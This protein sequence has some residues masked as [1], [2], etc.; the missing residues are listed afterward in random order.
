MANLAYLASP[1]S[2]PSAEVR[3]WRF[4]AACLAV[5]DFMRRG[6]AVFSPVVYSH[7]TAE[8]ASLPLDWESWKDFDTR[9]LALCD[10]LLV[11]T[12]PGW[13]DSRG[14]SEEIRLARESGKP[15]QFVEP[16]VVPGWQPPGIE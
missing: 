10:S 14:V 12:L 4:E 13:R 8:I 15:V 7:S 3:R 2:H 5:A 6:V 9:F 11:L 16:V 1:Y